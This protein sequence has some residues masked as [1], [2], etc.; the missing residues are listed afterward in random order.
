MRRQRD[1]TGRASGRAHHVDA[2]KFVHLMTMGGSSAIPPRAT[3]ALAGL[4]DLSHVI[5]GPLRYGPRL[6]HDLGGNPKAQ[7]VSRVFLASARSGP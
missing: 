6:P 3:A 7:E 4:F 5:D 2:A 1:A